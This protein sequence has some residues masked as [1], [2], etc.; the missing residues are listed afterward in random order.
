MLPLRD[1]NLRSNTRR[2]IFFSVELIASDS[3]MFTSID[4][5]EFPIYDRISGLQCFFVELIPT[6]SVLFRSGIPVEIYNSTFKYEVSVRGLKLL[7][8]NH[9]KQGLRGRNAGLKIGILFCLRL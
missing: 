2:T 7:G 4:S 9:E 6:T 8:T 5:I 3:G 1:L